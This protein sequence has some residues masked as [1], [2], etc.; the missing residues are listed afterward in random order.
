MC[1]EV[2]KHIQFATHT[3]VVLRH[4]TWLYSGKKS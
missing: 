3:V 1:D 4:L 2:L